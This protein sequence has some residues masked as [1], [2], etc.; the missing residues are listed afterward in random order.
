MLVLARTHRSADT[1]DHTVD[2]GKG[3]ALHD[4]FHCAYETAASEVPHD[5]CLDWFQAK[6]SAGIRASMKFVQ[7]WM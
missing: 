5:C 3:N 1:I 6:Q 2:W 7:G 4:E